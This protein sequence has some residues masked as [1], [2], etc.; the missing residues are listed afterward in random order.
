MELSRP[1]CGYHETGKFFNDIPGSLRGKGQWPEKIFSNSA[2]FLYRRTLQRF[3]QNPTIPFP[4]RVLQR[5]FYQLFPEKH[6]LKQI[7]K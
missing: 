5:E 3:F 4:L 7:L 6:F 2:A 1:G